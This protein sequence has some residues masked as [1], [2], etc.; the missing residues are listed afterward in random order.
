MQLADKVTV[1]TGSGSGFGE[2]I[3]K[4][5][6]AEGASVV[7]SDINAEGGQRVT[8]EI[9]AAGGTVS[10]CKANVTDAGE[11]RALID[12]ARSA[13][14]RLDILVNNAGVSHKRKPMTEVTEDELDHIFAVNVKGL[15][16]TANAAIPVMRAQGGGVIVNIASTG[17][18]QPGRRRYAAAAD[19]PGRGHAGKPRSL[20]RHDPARPPIDTRRR[21]RADH[22]C[23]PGDRRR[24]VYLGGESP[25]FDK[26]RM[27]CFDRYPG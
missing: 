6:A 3:A 11:T 27:R 15:F 13:F 8:E 10:F 23:M 24:P 25:S 9:A 12:H 18:G 22:R 5:C 2:G 26:L 21:H 20:P 4:A 7:V 14:G 17:A 16:H 1:I 19:L